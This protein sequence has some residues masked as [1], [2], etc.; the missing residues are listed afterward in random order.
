VISKEEALKIINLLHKEIRD[1][2][3]AFKDKQELKL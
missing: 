3:E 1:L 2:G